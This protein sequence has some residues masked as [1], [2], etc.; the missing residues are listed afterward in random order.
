M[1]RAWVWTLCLLFVGAAQARQ[2]ELSAINFSQQRLEGV[3]NPWWEARVEL[4]SVGVEPVENIT[5]N[6]ALSFERGGKSYYFHGSEKVLLIDR[7]VCARF[8]FLGIWPR[9]ISFLFAPRIIC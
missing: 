9:P 5:L 7:N 3:V 4:R 1:K 8:L 2:V 6:L